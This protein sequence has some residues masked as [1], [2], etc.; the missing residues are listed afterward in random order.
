MIKIIGGEKSNHTNRLVRKKNRI[1]ICIYRLDSD[2]GTR[3]RIEY[4]SSLVKEEI[5]DIINLNYN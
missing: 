5:P 1:Y 3:F 4:I 2:C